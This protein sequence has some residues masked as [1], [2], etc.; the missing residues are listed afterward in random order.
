MID[1]LVFLRYL[2]TILEMFWFKDR[3]PRL[4]KFE[5]IFKA[6]MSIALV[7]LEF[8]VI[9]KQNKK[10]RLHKYMTEY[11][12]IIYGIKLVEIV[13]VFIITLFYR[14]LL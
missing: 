13:L 10:I 2:Y 3:Y 4:I 11:C 12:K 5:V 6:T 1:F 9:K 8:L 7:T 14:D